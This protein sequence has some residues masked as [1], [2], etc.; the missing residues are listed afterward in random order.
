M[1]SVHRMLIDML[2]ELNRVACDNGLPYFLAYGTLLGAVRDQRLIAWDTDVD[3]LV[4]VDRYDALCR[5]LEAEL[6][7]EMCLLSPLSTPGYEQ[8]FSRVAYRGI[9]HKIL[10]IDL[11]PLGR[12]PESRV[13]RFSYAVFVKAVNLAHMLKL[14]AI[15]EKLH[16]DLRKRIIT[17]LAKIPLAFVPSRVLLWGMNRV[18]RARFRGGTVADSCGRFGARQFFEAAWFNSAT[19]VELDGRLFKAPRDK[20]RYLERV[21]GDFMTPVSAEQQAR[22][23]DIAELYY[24]RPLQDLGV[25]AAD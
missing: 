24:V 18:R 8:T 4:P 11:Y 21:Y 10:R 22:E 20:E 3:V 2:T 16:Y 9:D 1:I 7:P 14:V 15:E 13:G 6:P 19:E 25:I 23:L 17:R 12:G 5:V